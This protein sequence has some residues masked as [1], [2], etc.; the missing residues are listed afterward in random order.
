MMKKTSSI[1]SAT[2]AMTLIPAGAFAQ[3]AAPKPVPRATFTATMEGQFRAIDANKD[4]ILTSAEITAGQQAQGATM[5]QRQTEAM[6]ARLD[7]NKDGSISRAEFAKIAN[8]ASVKANPAGMIA[9]MDSSKDG[10]ISLAE[11][12]AAAQASFDMLDSNKDGVVGPDELRAA[13]PKR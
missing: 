11:F 3:Q 2:V 10:K 12:R 9:Q 13:Q 1:I 6:F 5:I 8:T 7:T 4:N